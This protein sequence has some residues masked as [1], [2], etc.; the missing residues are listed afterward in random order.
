MTPS[1]GTCTDP[2]QG[3]PRHKH[4]SQL[5]HVCCSRGLHIQIQ[6]LGQ[7][8]CYGS[9]NLL[10]VSIMASTLSWYCMLRLDRLRG[11]TRAHSSRPGRGRRWRASIAARCCKGACTSRGSMLSISRARIPS[12]KARCSCRNPRCRRI[13]GTACCCRVA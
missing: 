5:D 10:Q 7:F 3:D 11:P 9:M 4:I 8:C 1:S 12:Y 13:L 6:N 2:R